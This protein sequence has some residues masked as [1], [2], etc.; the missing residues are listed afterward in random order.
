MLSKYL[1]MK[2]IQQKKYQ[3]TLK[4]KHQAELAGIEVSQQEG[5]A[6]F[7]NVWEKYTA[8]YQATAYLSLQKLQV[9]SPFYL[10]ILPE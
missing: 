10:C 7:V 8:E 9:H 2:E 1:F 3:Q 6:E 5:F 4:S